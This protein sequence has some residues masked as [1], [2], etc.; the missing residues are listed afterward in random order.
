MSV[1]VISKRSKPGHFRYFAFTLLHG[2]P[3]FT[4]LFIYCF[5]V[6]R[7]V[8]KICSVIV[9]SRNLKDRVFSRGR[10]KGSVVGLTAVELN[11]EA[12]IS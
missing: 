9:G 8:V 12:S 1:Y 11:S 2:Q 10:S 7:L 3:E 5:R 6:A 4:D